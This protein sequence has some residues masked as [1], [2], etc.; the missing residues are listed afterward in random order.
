MKIYSLNINLV[1]DSIDLDKNVK[2][3][4]HFDFDSENN[5]IV[6]NV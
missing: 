1:K 5:F 3:Y 2:N 6:Q 4:N